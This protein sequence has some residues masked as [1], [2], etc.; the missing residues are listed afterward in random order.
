MKTVSNGD[1]NRFF[2]LGAMPGCVAMSV[3]RENYMVLV[4]WSQ[5]DLRHVHT[6]FS[7]YRD[8]LVDGY[9]FW[10]EQKLC[11]L[12]RCQPHN[13]T[14][15]SATAHNCATAASKRLTIWHNQNALSPPPAGKLSD[16]I[17]SQDTLY[18]S[19]PSESKLQCIF[20][21]AFVYLIYCELES[22]DQL[23]LSF[24]GIMESRRKYA[25]LIKHLRKPVRQHLQQM[26]T[27]KEYWVTA[28]PDMGF[29]L[30]FSSIH[31]TLVALYN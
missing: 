5:Q 20:S 23:H 7:S 24:D 13:S 22:E 28:Q 15:N 21:S 3:L 27:Y 31:F 19:M 12:F 2:V 26:T 25:S 1:F 10:S 29:G 14:C 30:C 18:N 9:T 16:L 17:F 11:F 4:R 6:P 8:V